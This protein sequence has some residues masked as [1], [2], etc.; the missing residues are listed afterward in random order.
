VAADSP[1]ISAAELRARL[2]SASAS[3]PSIL[4]VRW[5]LA[6]VPPARRDLY[7]DGHIPGAAFVDLDRD[8]SAP[9]GSAG[10][11]PLPVPADFVAAMRAAGIFAQ[12]PV[13]VYDA[14]TS[15]PAARA[16]WLLRNYGHPDVRVLDG[17]LAAWA[18]AGG[19]LTGG[20][21]TPVVGDFDGRPGAMPVLDAEGAAALARSGVLLDARAPERYRGEI[22]PLDRVGGHIP[23]ARNLPMTE[24]LQPT[25]RFRDP[26]AL[27]DG[28]ARAGAGETAQIGAYCGSGITA[29]H[30]VLALELAGLRGALYPGSWSEWVTDRR[31]PVATGA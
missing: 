28:F 22:E 8:L 18:A 12:R 7:E 25:G 21:E 20:S 26:V 30:T 3:P 31:R 4:D 27:R 5:E 6:A 11:H 15:L 10:R 17:G 16:W 14:A 2:G 1:L 9:P 23:G 24:Q 19:E 13:V 29:A